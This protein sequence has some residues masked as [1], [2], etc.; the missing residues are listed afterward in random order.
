M[1]IIIFA[2]WPD[3]PVI[4]DVTASSNNGHYNSGG[5]RIV[6]INQTTVALGVD[7]NS[8]HIYRSTDNGSSWTKIDDEYGYSGCLVSGKDNY[9][10]HFSGYGGNVR[11]VKFLYD[12]ETIPSP[13]NIASYGGTTH[14]AYRQINATVN[15]AG[16][17]FVFYHDD[18][19]GSYDTIYM[20]KST[21]GGNNWS[22][23]IIVRAGNTDHSWGF[24]HSDVTP[25]GNIVIV[26]SEWESKSIQ[27]AVSDN[28][29]DTWTHT[30]IDT[31]DAYNPA[32]LP[33]GENNL[34]V[35]AQ[36]PAENGL[37]FKKSTDS[38]NTWPSNWTSIQA[39]HANGYADPSP[40]LDDNGNIYVAFRGTDSYTVYSDDLREYIAMSTDG[41]TNWTFPYNNLP[42]GRV[43]T[44]SIMRYQTWHNYGGPLEWTW[45]E[46]VSEE[47]PT[48]FKINTDITIKNIGS[49]SNN[50]QQKSITFSI[51]PNPTN[52]I[53][54]I[55]FY[56][57]Q[58][59]EKV[60]ISDI[61]GKTI[62]IKR[63]IQQNE[64][65]DLSDFENGIY[66]ISIQTDNEIFT[67]K[68][69]KK[70]E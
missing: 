17:L 38:G 10:Y 41:G 5:R 15:A 49:T 13:I 70:Q 14:G 18:N 19:G 57:V 24:I 7:G 53:V 43:G 30:Q 29:G 4:I 3:E 55:N 58:N 48:L 11:V 1:P 47:Y 65:I 56:K 26:Y 44:R 35:F 62:I 25:S 20:I 34:Y 69:I 6:R 8:D 54:N 61:T 39:N 33:E 37:V 23:P 36:S 63:I 67:R 22:S 68:I 32:V 64:T 60:E 45:L 40:A 28:A 2:D 27:F 66:I 16:D 42:G 12:A 31:N 21:D 59:F 52:G 51:Y 46:D 9:I 50:N